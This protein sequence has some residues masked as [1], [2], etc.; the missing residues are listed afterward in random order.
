MILFGWP[1]ASDSEMYKYSE[2]YSSHGYKNVRYTPP[3]TYNF[4]NGD[5]IHKTAQDFFNFFTNQKEFNDEFVFVHVFSNLGCSMYHN[6]MI[7]LQDHSKNI[8]IRGV[9][10]D[11]CPGKLSIKSFFNTMGF[12]LGGNVLR[13]KTIPFFYFVYFLWTKLLRIIIETDTKS[14]PMFWWDGYYELQNPG[15]STLGLFHCTIL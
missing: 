12:V 7:Q 1:A 3:W 14:D 5:K 10:F 2:M 9:I 13:R 4:L 6:F 15:N 11:S 8:N